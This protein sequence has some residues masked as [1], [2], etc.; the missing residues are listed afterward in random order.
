MNLIFAL[1]CPFSN[2]IFQNKKSLLFLLFKMFMILQY[3]IFECWCVLGLTMLMTAKGN[4]KN[5]KSLSLFDLRS[6]SKNLNQTYGWTNRYCNA[7]SE[8]GLPSSFPL[9]VNEALKTA[10]MQLLITLLL[11]QIK[12]LDMLLLCLMEEQFFSYR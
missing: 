11:L 1:Q 10:S 6:Q 5:F 7:V 3:V 4:E 2:N 9:R 12:V 8:T